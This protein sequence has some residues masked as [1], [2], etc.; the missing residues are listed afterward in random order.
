MLYTGMRAVGDISG[1]NIKLKMGKPSVMMLISV[2][3]L[4]GNSKV[5]TTGNYIRKSCCLKLHIQRKGVINSEDDNDKLDTNC[6]L[7]FYHSWHLAIVDNIQSQPT[8]QKS[9]MVAIFV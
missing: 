8:D 5:T 9:R 6:F 2:M 7:F 1:K 3:L 4:P